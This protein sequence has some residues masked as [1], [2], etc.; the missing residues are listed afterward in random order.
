MVVA[1]SVACFLGFLLFYR[2]FN[3]ECDWGHR[4]NTTK[5]RRVQTGS[6]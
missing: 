4:D 3:T 2:N 5:E 1:S 6:S